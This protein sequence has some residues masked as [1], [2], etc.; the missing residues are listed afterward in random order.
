[1]TFRVLK[2]AEDIYL[3]EPAGRLDLLHSTRLKE[4]VM[5]LLDRKVTSIIINL[6][7]VPAIDSSGIG[8]LINISSTL[9]KLDI[10]FALAH[11][12][13]PL[14]SVMETLNLAGYFPIAAD[15]RSALDLVQS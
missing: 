13:A 4:T 10:P 3:I 6:E 9:R 8:A 7:T 2:N 1:M 12:N 14:Q 15:L 11:L 5:K